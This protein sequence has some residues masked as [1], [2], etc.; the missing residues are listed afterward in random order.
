MI[1]Y[2]PKKNVCVKSISSLSALKELHINVQK[3]LKKKGLI[4][5]KIKIKF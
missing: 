4:K 5:V 3:N 1:L 2:L